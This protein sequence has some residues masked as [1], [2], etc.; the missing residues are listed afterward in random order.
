M[1]IECVKRTDN[2]Y[3]KTSGSKQ[4]LCYQRRAVRSVRANEVEIEVVGML[5]V[6]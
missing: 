4:I 3:S 1:R 6:A 5:Q 2:L